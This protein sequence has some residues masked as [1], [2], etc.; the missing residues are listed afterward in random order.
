MKRTM[1][2]GPLKADCYKFLDIGEDIKYDNLQTIK[3]NINSEFSPF[4]INNW[5]SG[6]TV[7]WAEK[8]LFLSSGFQ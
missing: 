2:L 7:E 6:L 3:F 4:Q 5:S 8:T 1:R